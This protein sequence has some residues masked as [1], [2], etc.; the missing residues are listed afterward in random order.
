LLSQLSSLNGKALEISL[1]LMKKT[2]TF[3]KQ[4]LVK[5]RLI[6]IIS[7]TDS[8]LLFP[9]LHSHNS[10][11]NAK[12][13]NLNLTNGGDELATINHGRKITTSN[14]IQTENGSQIKT[15]RAIVNV[16]KVAASREL[17]KM[18]TK[19]LL[20]GASKGVNQVSPK[21]TKKEMEIWVIFSENKIIILANGRKKNQSQN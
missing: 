13:Y 12:K 10:Q 8:K 5:F 19:H 15:I 4:R 11:S 3:R 6:S 2:L 20:K 9:S 21:V 14:S 7:P 16:S 17:P 1:R 18:A